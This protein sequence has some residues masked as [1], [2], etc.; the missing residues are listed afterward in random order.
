MLPLLCATT[1]VYLAKARPILYKLLFGFFGK[2]FVG[3]HQLC[4]WHMK[5]NSR[6]S[7]R[8]VGHDSYERKT[9]CDEG[10]GIYYVLQSG[11]KRFVSYSLQLKSLF[12]RLIR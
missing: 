8:V 6:R 9:L 1:P 2:T 11:K 10:G 4:P 12:K 5:Q 3:F 7:K